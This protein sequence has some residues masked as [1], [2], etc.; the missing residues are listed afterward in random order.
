MRHYDELPQNLEISIGK[1]YIAL[2]MPLAG[3]P[4]EAVEQARVHP[5]P[6]SFH[7]TRRE[8]TRFCVN[9]RFLDPDLDRDRD[10]TS[11]PSQIFS[12]RKRFYFYT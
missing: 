4:R 5:S 12:A 9:D 2:K 8:R 10:P 3:I 1:W 6:I 11:L 7:A